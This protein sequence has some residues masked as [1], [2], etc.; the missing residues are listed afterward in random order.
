MIRMNT[1]EGKKDAAIILQNQLIDLMLNGESLNEMLHAVQLAL[2]SQLLILNH[3]F[4]VWAS[5]D[6]AI[7]SGERLDLTEIDVQRDRLV[8]LKAGGKKAGFLV[9]V[10]F[11]QN[12]ENE[13]LL[14]EAAKLCALKLGQMEQLMA[15]KRNYKDAFLFDLLYGNM[16]NTQEIISR[17]HLWGW[18]LAK[19][20]QVVVFEIRDYDQYTDSHALADQMVRI[21][22]GEIAKSG[23]PICMLK[24]GEVIAA[25]E[26]ERK[27]AKEERAFI[28]AFFQN[29]MLKFREQFPNRKIR[30]G[31]G[32]KYRSPLDIFRSYQEGKIALRLGELLGY[33]NT[34][35]F[36]GE[37]GLTRILYNH[38]KQELLEFYKET[39]EPLYS[40]ISDQ[41]NQ[42]MDTLEQ[43]LLKNGDLKETAQS[44]FLHPNTLRY[45]LKK[46]EEIL[47]I[48][49]EDLD[50]KLSLITAFKIKH[51]INL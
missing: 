14:E 27:T 31:V 8:P 7:R 30:C 25:L 17:G 37:L 12:D 19:P 45:R 48:N 29:V 1:Y 32:R 33:E 6:P 2:N 38:D 5:T 46:I 34:A 42:L 16:E 21:V 4:I 39:L 28:H 20:H 40:H 35:P 51:L 44:L 9:A 18:D 23:K 22:S 50:T 15:V 11:G 13:N 24:G 36:F 43:Y 49:L 10:D 26:M 3:S 47:D 41:G